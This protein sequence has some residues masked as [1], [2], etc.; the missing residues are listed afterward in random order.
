[1]ESVLA[2]WGRAVCPPVTGYHPSDFRTTCS[3]VNCYSASN[4]S[5]YPG[6]LKPTRVLCIFTTLSPLEKHHCRPA[7]PHPENTNSGHLQRCSLPGRTPAAGK[8]GAEPTDFMDPLP[9]T[10]SVLWTL[11]TPTSVQPATHI[12]SVGVF[13]T[14]FP[15]VFNSFVFPPVNS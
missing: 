8:G 3:T 7:E 9:R 11:P 12:N 2:G 14:T 4:P 1:M 13:V 15:R 5:K 6:H 10:S